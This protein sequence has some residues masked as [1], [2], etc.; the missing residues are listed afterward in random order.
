MWKRVSA[1]QPFYENYPS[2]NPYTEFAEGA[3][4]LTPGQGSLDLKKKPAHYMRYLYF[5]RIANIVWQ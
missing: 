5:R 3:S 2:N 1:P 4:A